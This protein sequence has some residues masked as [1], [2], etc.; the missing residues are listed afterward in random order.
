MHMEERT[1]VWR[2]MSREVLHEYMKWVALLLSPACPSQPDPVQM[3]LIFTG[4]K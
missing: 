1:V 3:R 4:E 2:G